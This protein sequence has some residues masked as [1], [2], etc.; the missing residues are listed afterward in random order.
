MIPAEHAL[1]SCLALKLWSLERHS[2]VMALVA[3]EGLALF[4][5]VLSASVRDSRRKSLLWFR[6]EEPE[7]Q[8]RIWK[9]IKHGL[10]NGE[11]RNTDA[12]RFRTDFGESRRHT[13]G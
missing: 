2:H 5:R 9:E 1:R 8:Q 4:L 11:V 6:Q 7:W 13:S 10:R 3:D 12:N